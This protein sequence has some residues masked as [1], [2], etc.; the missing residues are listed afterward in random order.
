LENENATTTDQVKGLIRDNKKS[1]ALLLLKL[2]TYRQKE[3]DLL[4][5]QLLT[6]LGMLQDLEWAAIH[7]QAMEALQTGT[8]ALNS[9]H[10]YMTPERVSA[11]LE[12]SNEALE[13]SQLLDTTG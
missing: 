12:D 13:V 7:V 4:D 10:A 1:R 6:V 9:I 11:L 8:A 2:R 3:L 5:A